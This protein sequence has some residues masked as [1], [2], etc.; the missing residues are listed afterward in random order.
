[1]GELIP[2]EL[3]TK[4]FVVIVNTIVNVVSK[5]GDHASHHLVVELRMAVE[6]A[7]DSRHELEAIYI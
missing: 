1:M 7:S 5:I 2:V 4:L 3:M 6:I